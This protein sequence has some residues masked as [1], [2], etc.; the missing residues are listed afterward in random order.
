MPTYAYLC[1]DCGN[2]VEV[3][4]KMSDDPLTACDSCGGGLRK[5]MFPVGIVFKGPGFYVND[6]AN[7]KSAT[8][9]TALPAATTDTKTE[10]KADS[11]P[12]AKTETKTETKTESAPK[13]ET[14]TPAASAA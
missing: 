8:K 7:K 3:I 11:T 1:D 2:E 12:D 4:Q 13:T 9:E 5:K 14:K 6:Y 10:A